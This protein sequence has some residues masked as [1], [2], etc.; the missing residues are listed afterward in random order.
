MAKA[1]PFRHASSG[2][3]VLSCSAASRS[4]ASCAPA[5]RAANTTSSSPSRARPGLC[6]SCNSRRMVETAAHLVD[7]PACAGTFQYA[8]LDHF[9]L[10]C[11]QVT[12]L[13]HLVPPRS[14]CILS[15]K[16]THFSMRFPLLDD[17]RGPGP[18]TP[19]PATSPRAATVRRPA[20]NNP[21]RR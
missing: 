3:S 14:V 2:P 10:V 15:T 11:R 17:R 12:K 1:D 20:W 8:T 6:P 16:H 9:S 5:A 19:A 18:K 7:H 13:Y 21:V 4:S